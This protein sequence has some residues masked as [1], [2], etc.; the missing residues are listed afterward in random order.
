MRRNLS[1]RDAGSKINLALAFINSERGDVNI[2][3]YREFIAA[4]KTYEGSQ[5]GCEFYEATK[6]WRQKRGYLPVSSTPNLIPGYAY[7]ANH[8]M[9]EEDRQPKKEKPVLAVIE[10]E[11][12]KWRKKI[13]MMLLEKEQEVTVEKRGGSLHV[14]WSFTTE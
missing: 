14:T 1:L 4:D 9:N 12:G 11:D 8:G 10:E 13:L 5:G 7:S 2:H 3:D 6:R